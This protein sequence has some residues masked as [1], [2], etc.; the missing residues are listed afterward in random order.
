MTEYNI[1][2]RLTASKD[3]KV[4]DMG[5]ENALT[6]KVNPAQDE[7]VIKDILIE[8]YGMTPEKIVDLWDDDSPIDKYHSNV[9]KTTNAI[10]FAGTDIPN[11][12]HLGS[13]IYKKTLDKDGQIE[14]EFKFWVYKT[15]HESDAAFKEAHLCHQELAEK[16]EDNS[17]DQLFR[18][19]GSLIPKSLKKP[20]YKFVYS[21][22]KITFQ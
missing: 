19:P 7:Q 20:K 3:K 17:I 8:A 15:P 13:F 12:S 16:E 4:K 5:V 22:L 2:A 11:C 10:S 6:F 9:V 1:S 21:D 18:Q 14:R